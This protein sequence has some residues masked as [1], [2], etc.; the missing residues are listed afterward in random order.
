MNQL[1]SEKTEDEKKE[2]D[3]KKEK[4]LPLKKVFRNLPSKKFKKLKN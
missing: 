2:E 1:P 3:V 4:K